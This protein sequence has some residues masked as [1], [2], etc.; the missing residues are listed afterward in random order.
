MR[1]WNLSSVARAR[2]VPNFGETSRGASIAPRSM[3]NRVFQWFGSVRL[4][5]GARPG[6]TR[7]SEA[8]SMTTRRPALYQRPRRA[9]AA[10]R[11]RPRRRPRPARSSPQGSGGPHG[12]R[13]GFNCGV[14]GE[15]DQPRVRPRRPK[16]AS[17]V[18]LASAILAARA[19]RRARVASC[20]GARR[21]AGG[22]ARSGPRGQGQR[23]HGA[24][25]GQRPNVAP[26]KFPAGLRAEDITCQGPSLCKQRLRVAGSSRNPCAIGSTRSPRR[27]RSAWV[28]HR[29]RAGKPEERAHGRPRGRTARRSTR[30]NEQRQA[31][32]GIGTIQGGRPRCRPRASAARSRTR[33][34]PAPARPMTPDRR[35]S[36]P[37]MMP[38]ATSS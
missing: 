26:H 25:T 24:G 10:G 22:P 11:C 17:P 16:A 21:T 36:T 15:A 3:P 4:T 32:R 9:D 8:S 27:S 20:R 28:E 5:A 7:G 37:S 33:R 30:H 38:R 23:G 35:P 6:P 31:Q 1:S 2:G 34:A 14:G 18:G 19:R 12:H 29:A 13:H